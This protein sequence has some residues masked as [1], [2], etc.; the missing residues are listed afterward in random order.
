VSP[1]THLLLGWLVANPGRL[2]RRDRG[3]ATAA[4]LAPDADGMGRV[5]EVATR[6]SSHPLLWFSDGC[7]IR[8]AAI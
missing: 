1:V 4:G 8:W 5:V 2:E 7:G 3:L 6:G